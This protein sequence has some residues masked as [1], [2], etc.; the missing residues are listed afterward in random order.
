MVF[1]LNKAY[2]PEAY[3]TT[4]PEMHSITIIIV[5]QIQSWCNPTT[6]NQV[7]LEMNLCC[8][9]KL[10]DHST[11]WSTARHYPELAETRTNKCKGVGLQKG[12]GIQEQ[13][14]ITERLRHSQKFF[15]GEQLPTTAFPPKL[16]EPD[17]RV[18]HFIRQNQVLLTDASIFQKV[19]DDI[20]PYIK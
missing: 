14:E 17:S 12:K 11:K 2:V 7:T 16:I 3:Y 6:F 18:W 9:A 1:D 5:G 20:T 15:I 10:S 8:S 4:V 13:K 19:H